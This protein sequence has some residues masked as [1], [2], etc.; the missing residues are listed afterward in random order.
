L[1]RQLRPV[2][3]K[4][5]KPRHGAWVRFGSRRWRAAPEASLYAMSL[6]PK[7]PVPERTRFLEFWAENFTLLTFENSN[8]IVLNSGRRDAKTSVCS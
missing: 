5:R 2:L 8:I 1:T 3:P 4:A 6:E 7:L